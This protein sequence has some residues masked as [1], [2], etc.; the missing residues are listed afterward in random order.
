M[1]PESLIGLGLRH[2]HYQ[3]VL[4]QNPKVAWFEVHSEN[5]FQYGGAA[6]GFLSSV[7]KKY[8][9]SLHGVGLSLGSFDL[10]DLAHLKKLKN[11]INDIQPFLVSEHLSWSRIGNQHLPDL[12]PISYTDESLKIFAKNVSFAQD[13]L[14]CQ[15][16]IENPSSYLQYHESYLHEAEFLTELCRQ[17]GCRILLDVNNI[18]VSCCNHGWDATLYLNKIPKDLVKEIH[19]AGHSFKD[20]SNHFRMRIDT[21]D[22]KVCHEVWELYGLAIRRFGPQFTLLEW[23]SN[24]PSLADLIQESTIALDYLKEA[25]YCA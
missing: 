4:S 9:M 25:I 16:L 15:L 21:H 5:F 10:P 17:T 18:F 6:L 11:L 2:P 14:N 12:I 1:H 20:L 22:Q 24:I 7:S 23:D 19:L 13:F 3:E 8:P